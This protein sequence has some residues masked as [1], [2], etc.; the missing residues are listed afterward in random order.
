VKYKHDDIETTLMQKSWPMTIGN[1]IQEGNSEIQVQE[2]IFLSKL[3]KE[4]DEFT[5]T[6]KEFSE[7]FEKIKLFDS[8][9][10]V[11]DTAK[12]T[13]DLK[14]QIELAREK[15]EQFNERE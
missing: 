13:S 15:I 12:E 3:D 10:A 6:L 1:V 4:K 9:D 14:A 2:E 7:R 5:V 8:I 11:N